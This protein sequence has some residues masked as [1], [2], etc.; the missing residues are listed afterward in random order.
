MLGKI[1]DGRRRGRQRM[2]WLDGITNLTDTSLSKLQELVMDREA[3]CAAVHGV[4]QSRTRLSNSSE[5]KSHPFIDIYFGP[6]HRHAR[7]YSPDQGSNPCPLQWKCAVLTTRPP[8]NSPDQTTSRASSS[9]SRSGLL[10][11]SVYTC[12]TSNN[13]QGAPRTAYALNGAQ[14]LAETLKR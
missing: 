13:H 12:C 4:A 8:G 10:V 1:E 14:R 9:Y 6:H 3:W 5:L 7:S 2:T 11:N